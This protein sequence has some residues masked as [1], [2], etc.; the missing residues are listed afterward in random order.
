MDREGI[1]E[2]LYRDQL[3]EDYTCDGFV[4]YN[5]DWQTLSEVYN[6]LR[7]QYQGGILSVS[8][9]LGYVFE[10]VVCL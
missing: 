3:V 2:L 10:E 1:A 9:V 8:Y 5:G 4:Q 7:K 6:M